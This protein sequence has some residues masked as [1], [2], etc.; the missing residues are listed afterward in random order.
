MAKNLK[1]NIVKYAKF[2]E[3]VVLNFKFLIPW[4]VR[5]NSTKELSLS[6]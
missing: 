4:I 5:K 3:I 1:K 6:D 2:L